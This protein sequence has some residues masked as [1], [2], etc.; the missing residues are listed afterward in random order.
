MPRAAQSRCTRRCGKYATKDG[1]C[2]D[3]Q[4]QPWENTSKRNQVLDRKLW[5]RA[6]KH[7]LTLEPGCRVCGSTHNVVVDHITEI[8]DGGAPYDDSNLQT[9][10][11]AHDTEK[12]AL[13][14][15]LRA[16]RRASPQG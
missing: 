12:T 1:R 3:H 4:R 6:K 16:A 7:H 13:A 5:E 9:L 10:C 15:R 11:G 8:A 2:D 14:R